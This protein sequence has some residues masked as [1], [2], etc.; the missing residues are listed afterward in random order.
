MQRSNENCRDTINSILDKSN[1]FDGVRG[2]CSNILSCTRVL[3]LLGGSEVTSEYIFNLL[4]TR[5][6][7]E[8]NPIIVILEDKLDYKNTTFDYLVRHLIS[9]ERRMKSNPSNIVTANHVNSKIPDISTVTIVVS[10]LS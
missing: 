4:L 9:F 10:I 8:F 5:L 6:T 2:F 7:P 1:Q 3:K